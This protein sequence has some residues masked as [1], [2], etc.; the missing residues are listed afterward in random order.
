[1]PEFDA[2]LMVDWSA[3]SRPVTGSDS[4]WY[5]LVVRTGDDLKIAALENPSTRRQA[6]KE[7]NE[8]LRGFARQEL[9]VLT[10][11]DFPYGYPAGFGDALGL[12][13]TAPWLGIWR[14]LAQRI[15]DR[16]DNSNNRFQVAGD[17][18]RHISGLCYPFW[19][20]PEASQSATM[21]S[22]KHTGHLAERRLTDIANMQPIWK[23]YGNGSVGSQSL[24]GIPHL[25]AL[26]NDPVLAPVSR[27]WPFETGLC[28]LPK[29]Q[30]RDYLILHAE[31]YPSLLPNER[32]K[33]QVKDAVQVRTMA[34]H[35]AALDE[36]GDL[37]S[38]FAGP[39]GLTSEERKRIEGEEG[40]TLGV[41]SGRQAEPRSLQKAGLRTFGD[42]T[43]RSRIEPAICHA[44]REDGLPECDFVYFA[45]PACGS[46]TI[47]ED[48]VHDAKA[49]IAHA[50]N[51]A[52]LRMPLIQQLRPGHQ[53][54]LV[55][56][57]DGKYSPMFRGEVCTSPKPVRTPKHT[58]DVFCYIAEEFHDRLR[59]SGYSP[60]PVV[61]RFTGISIASLQNLRGKTR[62]ITKPKGNNTLRRW[63]EVFPGTAGRESR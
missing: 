45:T 9:M 34:A 47:T 42:F 49:I 20:C 54:L 40:W 13:D 30:Q 38:L 60:D 32:T 4:V 1:M 62:K 7:I 15:V 37:S 3:S 39:A 28:V 23:L 58:F 31:I 51:N 57:A 14:D 41:L 18:N 61:N 63:D 35:F 50:Y 11:F 48:F 10:G 12:T 26:R 6:V 36:S 2:Y 52:G 16:H 21:S 55:Y 8:I 19:G 17:L 33:E 59:A 43:S 25:A 24:L 22:T 5:C 53:I 27:V 29:R 56:G 44:N 46:W